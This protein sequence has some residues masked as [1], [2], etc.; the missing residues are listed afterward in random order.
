MLT[1]V[2]LGFRAIFAAVGLY[3]AWCLYRDLRGLPAT[4][5]ALRAELSTIEE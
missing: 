5:R 1:F 4:V 3:A 2:D